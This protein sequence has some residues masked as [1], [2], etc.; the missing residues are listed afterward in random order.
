MKKTCSFNNSKDSFSDVVSFSDI[1]SISERII[2]DTFD[3]ITKNYENKKY[4]T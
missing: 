4:D 2:G 3:I 1:V